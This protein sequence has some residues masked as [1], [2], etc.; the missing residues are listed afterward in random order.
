MGNGER[1]A[2]LAV[3]E[4][5]LALVVGRPNV[6]G[7]LGD[8]LGTA[9]VSAAEAASGTGEAFTEEDTAGGGWGGEL[10]GG[11]PMLHQSEQ[12]AGAPE[13]VD[14]AESEQLLSDSRIGLG[15]GVVGAARELVEAC[16]AVP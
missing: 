6:V 5:E 1:E 2:V 13:G 8:G 16:L 15:G 3:L 4:A 11:V 10:P 12:L 9:W 14:P 7:A